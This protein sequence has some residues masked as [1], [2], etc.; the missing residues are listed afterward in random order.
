MDTQD[1]LIIYKTNVQNNYSEEINISDLEQGVI[2]FC[3]NEFEHVKIKNESKKT[4]IK[5]EYPN[6]EELLQINP[7]EDKVL[8]DYEY[9]RSESENTIFFPEKYLIQIINDN[10]IKNCFFVVSSNA[11]GEKIEDI[12]KIISDF[13]RGLELDLF[14][15]IRGKKYIDSKNN[16]FVPL[17]EKITNNEKMLQFELNYIVNFPLQNIE[18]SL[19]YTKKVARVSRKKIK[20]DSK[21]GIIENDNRKKFAEK[22]RLS[23][24]TEPNIVLKN[25]LFKIIKA[26]NEL[27]DYFYDNGN[28]LKENLS[29]LNYNLLN[30]EKKMKSLNNRHDIKYKNNV[31][32]EYND[33][34]FTIN[35]LEKEKNEFLEK[36][37][38]INRIRNNFINIMNES[39]IYE[40][41]TD[42][43]I[44]DSMPARRNIHYK[45]ILDF[46]NS[47]NTEYSN[48]YNREGVYM[49]KKTSELYE[50]YVL[51]LVFK[52]FINMDYIF[53]INSKYDFN[54]LFENEEF[55]F[56]KKNKKIRILYNKL[57]KRTEAEPMDELVN[58]NSSS[59]KPDI[60]IMIYDNNKL[61]HCIVLEVKCRKKKNIYSKNGDTPVFSQLKDYTNFWYF[62]HNLK[63]KKDVID[64]VY[65]IYP[66]MVS[67][68]DFLNANQICLLSLEPVYDYENSI[69]F[70]NLLEELKKFL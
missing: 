28:Y 19:E 18:K 33:L 20:Y 39:W 40:I 9:N 21:K 15:S 46:V 59:N 57:V 44:I 67:S 23:L 49:Y 58:Q 63:L 54:L 52:I 27:D 34:L 42:Y 43:T 16:V 68:K 13:S 12:R 26:C 60:V 29:K 6:Q 17:F 3:F 24:N 66:D 69:G 4:V 48:I 38:I 37:N 22:K 25:S 35:K 11:L 53:S 56:E 36:K 65:A 70:R 61:I 45:K 10:L 62:D 47:I 51:I 2:L 64:R 41:E 1:K 32:S 31:I 30:V 7:G 8:N 14:N 55:I 5:C 50:I